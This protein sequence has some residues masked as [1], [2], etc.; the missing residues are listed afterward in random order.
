MFANET[1]NTRDLLHSRIRLNDG[2][3]FRPD[4]TGDRVWYQIEDTAQQR[5]FCIGLP[6]Y[7]FVSLLDGDTSP[8]EA[9]S[10]TA[11]ALGPDA[12]T[13]EQAV[14]I[15]L[16]LQESGL[17]SGVDG[18]ATSG[19][20][21]RDRSLKKQMERLNPFWM[22][23]P[24]ANPDRV[25]G[26][27]TTVFRWFFSWPAACLVTLLC[28]TALLIL[29]GQW[30]EFGRS[31]RSILSKDNWLWLMGVWLILKLIHESAHAI[32]CR[33]LG[34]AVPE[35]GVIL[36]LLAPLAYVD[37]TSSLKFR[38]KWQRIQIAAAG[39]YTEITLGS[40]ALIL[41]SFTSA[42]LPRHLL[43][44]VVIMASV[45]TILFNANPLMRFDGYYILSDLLEIPNLY[46]RGTQAVKRLARKVLTGRAPAVQQSDSGLTGWL[47]TAYGLA[48][49][50]WRVLVC[51]SLLIAASVLFHGLGV[52]LTAVGILLWV[53]RPLLQGLRSAR[54]MLRVQAAEFLRA[55]AIATALL[56]L[57]GGLLF[58]LPWPTSRVA[59]GFV[60]YRDLAVVRA[61][62][63]GF[64]R[65]IHVIDGQYVEAGDILLEVENRELAVEVG[66]LQA[67]IRQ[68]RL[69][70]DRS[71]REHDA[72]TAQVEDED[73]AALENRLADKQK[74][75]NALTVHAPVSGIVMARSL[76]WRPDTYVQEGDELIAVGPDAELEF[77]ASVAET[78]A[79]QLQPD[80]P[81][82]IRLRGLSVNAR[83]RTIA[84]RAS[85][86]PAH[87]SLIATNG[88]PLPVRTRSEQDDGSDFE[89]ITPRITVEC[90]FEDPAP[91]RLSSGFEGSAALSSLEATRLGPMLY[92][93]ASRFVRTQLENGSR[94][95]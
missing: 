11:R 48:A 39:M 42:E 80:D 25:V 52:I 4:R 51:V 76:R 92:R 7:T 8:A 87:E 21:A 64:I 73:R 82:R 85:R 28:A 10:L 40:L 31:S 27:L 53:G 72:A 66:D 86:I 63:P 95:Q 89:L 38:S 12:L 90:R 16:W 23:I 54:R 88:G 24:L 74:Q 17:A 5:F 77:H 44:N 36:I 68:S 6:E 93:V 84:P 79:D 14:S 34:A 22:K 65:D 58:L 19:S 75:L 37:V 45:T 32:A 71:L 35:T 61:A 94:R 56:L 20:A 3:M 81:V 41:W 47:I 18:N 57:A 78:D 50:V 59:P 70:Y 33:R 9:I 1:D 55:S 13:E 83:I 60:E 69:R 91:K 46:S 26:H 67:A 2:L 29:S 62:G 30:E 49:L 43:H 15:L